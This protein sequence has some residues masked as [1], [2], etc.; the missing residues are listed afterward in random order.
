MA[1]GVIKNIKIQGVTCA[2]PANKMNTVDHTDKFELEVLERVADQTGVKSTY[3]TTEK[4]TASDLCYEAAEDVIRGLGWNKDE[5]GAL[6]LVTHALDYRRPST[7]SVIHKRLGLNKDCTAMDINLGCSGFVYGM[8][9]LGALMTTSEI[10]KAILVCGDLSSKAVDPSTTSNLLFGDI[11]AAIAFEKV[12]NC[13]DIRYLLRSDGSRFKAIFAR[14]GGFRHPEDDSIY[15]DMEGMD[16][17]AFSISDVPKAILEFMQKYEISMD[18]IDLVALH[19]ANELIIRKAAKKI[20]APLEK[21]PIVITEYGNSS[22][23][24]IPL[25]IA[26]TVKKEGKKDRHILMSGFGLGLSWGVADVCLTEDVYVSMIETNNYYDD[27]GDVT[28]EA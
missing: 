26:D 13:A 28:K 25:V 3:R 21:T 23:S 7:S 22:S 5:I 20:K 18:D 14:G 27:D 4:Q 16:V 2:L 17:F 19:Q 15:A 11:G 6:I 24:S 1:F 9:V 8:S 10:D 12:E